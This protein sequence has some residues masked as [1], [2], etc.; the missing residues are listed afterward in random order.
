MAVSKRCA[1]ES[2][3]FKLRVPGKP[4]PTF[5]LLR[6]ATRVLLTA[7][8]R[9]DSIRVADKKAA[10]GGEWRRGGGGGGGRKSCES[11]PCP[12]KAT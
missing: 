10:A 11:S 1:E 4:I 12:K 6:R 8:H 5:Q 3:T 7:R 9:L 2:R